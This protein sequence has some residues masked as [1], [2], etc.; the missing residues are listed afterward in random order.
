[1]ENLPVRTREYPPISD[2]EIVARRTVTFTMKTGSTQIIDGFEYLVDGE[3]DRVDKSDPKVKV[4]AA[5]EWR[6]VNSSD[7]IH[8]F[9][10]HVDLEKLAGVDGLLFHVE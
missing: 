3:L 6:I 5:E 1:M 2:S 4:G 8:P 9:H 7:G 10:I